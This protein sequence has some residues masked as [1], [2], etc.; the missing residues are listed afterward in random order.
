MN[1]VGFGLRIVLVVSDNFS[2]FD[3]VCLK[4]LGRVVCL[5]CKSFGF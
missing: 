5:M 4:V 1:L 2:S 3:V